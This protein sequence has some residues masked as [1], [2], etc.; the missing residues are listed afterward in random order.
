[1]KLKGIAAFSIILMAL[2]VAPQAASDL[3]E[4]LGS[5]AESAHTAFLLAVIESRTGVTSSPGKAVSSKEHSTICMNWA[6]SKVL[7]RSRV[8]RHLPAG[9]HRSSADTVRVPA[10]AGPQIELAEFEPGEIKTAGLERLSTM[11]AIHLEAV[12]RIV[13]K[14]AIISGDQRKLMNGDCV[15]RLV[16][17][18]LMEKNRN[19]HQLWRPAVPVFKVS[20]ILP[21]TFVHSPAGELPPVADANE[22]DTNESRVNSISDTHEANGA[23]Q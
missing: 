3:R 12:S 15:Q 18:A 7:P 6:P 17:T 2:I 14:T 11:D 1:M 20:R 9:N 4:F 8:N 13:K 10:N 16:K 5:I 23:A 21:E 19:T 22:G